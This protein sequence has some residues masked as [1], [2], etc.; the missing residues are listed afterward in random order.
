MAPETRWARVAKS[1]P[2]TLPARVAATTLAAKARPRPRRITMDLA[3]CPDW[4]SEVTI[5]EATARGT[6]YPTRPPKEY[7]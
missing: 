4:Y 2:K 1:A 6:M 3:I 7:T 5:R